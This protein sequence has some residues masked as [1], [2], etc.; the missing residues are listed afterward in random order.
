MAGQPEHIV[1]FESGE[2]LKAK[3]MEEAEEDLL[4]KHYLEVARQVD[5]V[6][7]RL[8]REREQRLATWHA[9]R[10]AAESEKEKGWWK[11]LTI[12]GKTKQ[13]PSDKPPV[14]A[15][16]ITIEKDQRPE[17]MAGQ[18]VEVDSEENRK[19]KL[20]EDAVQD[21]IR[22]RYLEV[23]RQV[24]PV[25]DQLEREREE[26]LATWHA[27]RAAAESKKAMGWWKR[28]NL[29]ARTKQPPLDKPPVSAEDITREK[30]QQGMGEQ[31][32]EVDSDEKRKAE[33]MSEL[34]DDLL[35]K[36]YCEVARLVD[37]YLAKLEDEMEEILLA[38]SARAATSASARAAQKRNGWWTWLRPSKSF[39]P[40]EKPL[41]SH[42][43][44]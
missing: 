39:Q 44:Q 3:L 35:R 37:P 6:V 9:K 42:G 2:K 8:E 29:W 31:Q 17:N 4:R 25:V 33:L 11:R 40:L 7:D 19:A 32:V 18:Q 20:I 16:D 41:L 14:S 30:D 27:K 36:Q 12:W 43:N 28:L 5:P 34:V 22:K 38:T 1:E 15:A 23:A 10:A 24:D 13:P 21:L 26:R